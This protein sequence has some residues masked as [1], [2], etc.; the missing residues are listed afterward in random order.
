MVSIGLLS[1]QFSLF[2]DQRSNFVE[3]AE[4]AIELALDYRVQ[5]VTPLS[6]FNKADVVRLATEKKISD[7]YSCHAG[8]DKS[9]G[10][11]IACLE[12]GPE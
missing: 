10:E 6:K 9:C 8:G 7:T 12:F 3:Q 2:P 1:E 4:C 5:I 11:C